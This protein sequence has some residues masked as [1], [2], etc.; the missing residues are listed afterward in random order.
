MS[1]VLL[2]QV[3]LVPAILREKIILCTVGK[4]YYGYGKLL[5]THSTRNMKILT[6][7]LYVITFFSSLSPYNFLLATLRGQFDSEFNYRTRAIISRGLY[8]FYPI[9]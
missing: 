7:S 1:G 3:L 9:F 4:N 5:L 8:I 2:A 6:R